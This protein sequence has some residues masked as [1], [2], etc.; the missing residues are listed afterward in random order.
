MPPR[1]SV[2]NFS[3]SSEIFPLG[4]LCGIVA[5]LVIFA[6]DRTLDGLHA[7]GNIK[8]RASA[9]IRAPEMRIGRRVRS[10]GLACLVL[11]L[12]NAGLPRWTC[13]EPMVV[14]KNILVA[15]DFSEP[16]G[17]AWRNGRDLASVI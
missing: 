1:G 8:K 7:R 11:T 12:G 14:I 9:D 4:L 5:D 10:P 15:T 16:S 13:E 2:G 3:T 6:F 17:V